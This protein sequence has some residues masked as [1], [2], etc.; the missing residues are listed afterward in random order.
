MLLAFSAA[1]SG[2]SG[3]SAGLDSTLVGYTRSSLNLSLCAVVF[4][5]EFED[6]DRANRYQNGSIRAERLIQGGGWGAKEAL[7]AH[8]FVLLNDFSFTLSSD[9]TWSSFRKSRFTGEF[10]DE[11][12]AI[13]LGEGE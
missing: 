7:R 2:A 1:V 9:T 4:E 13:V 5:E 12:L 11:M 6:V 3:Q 10:C 8:D